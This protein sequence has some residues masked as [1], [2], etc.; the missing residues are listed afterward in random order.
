MRRGP[1]TRASNV[2]FNDRSTQVHG[3]GKI[4]PG[5][6]QLRIIIVWIIRSKLKQTSRLLC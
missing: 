6:I 4:R 3:D 1:E 2:V 5:L